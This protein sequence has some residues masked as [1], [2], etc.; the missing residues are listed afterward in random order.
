MKLHPADKDFTLSSIDPHDNGGFDD[1][2]K[3]E[4][5]AKRDLEKL[6]DLHYR[7]F[8]EN[9]RSLLII[10]Q[11]MDAGGK[12]GTIRHL[13]AGLNPQG[14]HVT[15]FKVPSGEELEHDYL[16]R[17]HKA[18][19]RRGEAAIFN[20]S[21]Y[22]EVLIVRVH[23]EIVEQR[24]FPPGTATG[25]DL[26]KERYRQINDF[27]RMLA[28][29]GTVILKFML[30]ISPEEQLE[31]IEKRRS[32]SERQWK[33]AESDMK[34]REHWD[35]YMTAYQK[36]IRHTST[37][38]APWYVIP[39]DRKWYRN[40]LIGRIIVERLKEL[41]MKFPKLGERVGD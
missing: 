32:D 18:A 9:K 21:Q 36:M 5:E 15:S 11:S 24:N 14:L 3:A 7:M 23:P 12:D 1:R 17:C 13:A 22:E 6:Y 4:E 29:N 19:P 39:A 35:E 31:R 38:H 33:Y 16:W 2:E 40:Y 37:S 34:E 27:E 25:D 8:A 30:H 20:R 28:E 41:E 10:L 26:F